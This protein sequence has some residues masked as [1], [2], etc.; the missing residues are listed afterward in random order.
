M[1]EKKRDTFKIKRESHVVSPQAKERQK[2]YNTIKKKIIEAMG[3][4]EM[5]V[6]QIAEKI[7]MNKTETLYY[8]MS[9]LKFNVIQTVRL[10]DMDEF[11]LYKIKR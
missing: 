1:E 9:L 10:D 11:Y 4:E 5:S 7:N 6:P 8:V 3:D 2:T